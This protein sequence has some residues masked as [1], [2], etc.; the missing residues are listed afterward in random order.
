MNWRSDNNMERAKSYVI[1]INRTRFDV[2]LAALQTVQIRALAGIP[3][4]HEL[5]VEGVG[6]H[7]DRLLGED[8]I[9]S[10]AHGPVHVY[11]KPPTVFG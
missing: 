3:R 5:I 1:Y 2:E 6:A 4:D 7:E 10:L 9:V 11:T 8:E